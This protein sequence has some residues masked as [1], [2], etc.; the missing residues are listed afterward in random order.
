MEDQFKNI[1]TIIL[2][3]LPLSEREKYFKFLLEN[4][5][6]FTEDQQGYYTA[7][8]KV[9]NSKGKT[10]LDQS[11]FLKSDKSRILE[12][13][14]S[15]KQKTV[16]T[17]SP[18]STSPLSLNRSIKSKSSRSPI[19]RNKTPNDYSPGR[20]RVI[21]DLLEEDR[22]SSNVIIT[23]K[24]NPTLNTS[25]T[26]TRTPEKTRPDPLKIFLQS[27]KFQEFVNCL[28]V[29]Q[30]SQLR[31]KTLSLTIVNKNIEEIYSARYK[32]ELED[33]GR[34]GD[35][36]FAEFVAEFFLEKC[37]NK[38][39]AD[40]S[41]LDFCQSVE[42]YDADNLEVRIF[43]DFLMN[44]LHSEVL[45]FFLYA[46]H[47]CINILGLQLVSSNLYLEFPSQKIQDP[48]SITLT[49]KQCISIAS[50]VY[51]E[52]KSLQ[53]SFLSHLQQVFKSPS[54]KF[55]EFLNTFIENFK[56][57]LQENTQS[58]S[59]F[60][61]DP[62]NETFGDSLLNTESDIMKS[63]NSSSLINSSKALIKD[64][65]PDSRPLP[66]N[67]FE[68]I[69]IMCID[70]CNNILVR[71]FVKIILSGY[72]DQHSDNREEI[73]MDVENLVSE[74]LVGLVEALCRCDKRKWMEVLETDNKESLKY[75]ESLQKRLRDVQKKG[76]EPLNEDID[77]I[78]K[79]ILQTPELKM[80]IGE[81]IRM[82]C[83]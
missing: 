15:S 16:I 66:R 69:R 83:Q 13:T 23:Q 24:S 33:R 47:T 34:K 41:A 55:Y 32:K 40:Q 45:I 21:T 79:E 25:R 49:S 31:P 20:S 67:P 61:S 70:H 5:V 35:L 62:Q 51:N 17:D 60:T 75:C 56:L 4:D 78:C 3:E 19:P 37:K 81:K 44:S 71:Q 39:M 74:K 57:S 63:I 36:G 58:L 9:V 54:I 12:S 48:R 43:S 18:R 46:R 26:S 10:Q 2:G 27:T 14:F 6:Q 28:K 72:L 38:R 29:Q 65:Q 50:S 7:I 68:K 59:P 73:I 53:E 22:L 42:T 52:E 80:R 64:P 82:I 11:T 77:M 1:P 8:I 30:S 76:S